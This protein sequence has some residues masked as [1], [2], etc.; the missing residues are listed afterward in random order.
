M[1][2]SF[3]PLPVE[4]GESELPVF[5]VV[6]LDAVALYEVVPDFDEVEDLADV[7]EVVSSSSK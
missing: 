3:L 1:G 2:S 4:K 7:V 5:D 6:P